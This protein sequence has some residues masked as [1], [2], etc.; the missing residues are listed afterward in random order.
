M[1][2][3]N[4]TI[5]KII[6]ILFAVIIIAGFSTFLSSA[7][8][9]TD[10]IKS[11]DIIEY[12][13]YPKY[14]VSSGLGRV[15]NMLPGEWKPYDYKYKDSHGKTCSGDM[16][17]YKDVTYGGYSYRGIL[18]KRYRP[19]NAGRQAVADS[20]YVDDNF[21]F[22]NSTFTFTYYSTVISF[23]DSGMYWFKYDPI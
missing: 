19:Y 14:L 12:G 21:F 7:V 5:N 17:Y 2:P 4:I 15:L 6:S 9:D 23:E 10:R 20:S 11:G 8:D 22:K 1:K 3:M 18:I 13:S 16:V